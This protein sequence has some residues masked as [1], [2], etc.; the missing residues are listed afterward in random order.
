MV[1]RVKNN[2]RLFKVDSWVFMLK[3]LVFF[4]GCLNDCGSRVALDLLDDVADAVQFARDV[5][6]LWAMG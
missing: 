3:E 2:Q 6:A 5:N 4:C 1:I